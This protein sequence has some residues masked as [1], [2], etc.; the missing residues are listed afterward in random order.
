MTCKNCKKNPVIELSGRE[1]L[2]KICFLKYF[3]RKV[4][5]TIREYSL[6]ERGDRILV[7]CSGGKDSTA[8]LYL[9]K[10][11]FPKAKIRAIHIDVGIKGYSEM[12]LKNLKIFCK[13]FKIKLY[14]YSLRKEF[15]NSVCY[16]VDALKEKG[17]KSNKCA[18][19]GSLRRRLLNKKAR[20]LRATKLVTG[21]NLDDEAQSIVMNLFKN[22]IKTM[23]RL[24]PK[25][26]AV[27]DRRFVQRVKPLYF[28]SEKETILF[29]KLMSLPVYYGKCPC[30]ESVFRRQVSNLIDEFEKRHPG[31]KNSIV[32]SFIGV[33]PLLKDK[34]KG[35]IGKC[36]YCKE[37][38]SKEVCEVCRIL[39]EIRT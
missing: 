24:G 36:R 19:C 21:H 32:N 15:G 30:S 5:R 2:C 31:T 10:K 12:N 3:E 26:G 23:A 14:E 29:S 22:N 34:Y 7:A 1:K 25:T 13:K 35:E 16:A 28:T 9:I 18:V 8:A 38:S 6:I 4:R 33:M 37:P 20:D 17:I 27:K 39:K 11:I